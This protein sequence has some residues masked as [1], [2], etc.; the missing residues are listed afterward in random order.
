ML[1]FRPLIRCN[2]APAS[3]IS[4]F[5]EPGF[6]ENERPKIPG[7]SWSIDMLKRKST[8]DLQTIWYTIIKEKNK[9]NTMQR[10][11]T[12]HQE[13]LGA[14]PAPSRALL[15]DKSLENIRK[16]LR[17]RHDRATERA[18]EIFEQRKKKGVYRYPPGPHEPPQQ[19]TST[20]IVT[21]SEKPLTDSIQSFFANEE[22]FESH[23]GIVDVQVRLPK[24]V[25]AK[26]EKAH[27]VFEEWFNAKR[28]YEDYRKYNDHESVWDT[29]QVEIAPG[30]YSS[31]P[32]ARE[33]PVPEPMKERDP[34]SD[35]MERLEWEGR[36]K[37]EQSLI[38]LGH[39]PNIT[40]KAPEHPGE[41]PEHPDEIAG[42]WEAE[43]TF[44]LPQRATKILE[45]FAPIKSIDGVE[46][47]SVTEV[48]F[49]YEHTY[50]SLPFY[51][52][53][54]Q[55][56]KAYQQWKKSSPLLSEWKDEYKKPLARPLIEIITHNYNNKI[57]YA[58]R[59]ARMMGIN[60]WEPP[61]PIDYTCG[62]GY[63][64]PLWISERDQ[65]DADVPR[66]AMEFGQ[67]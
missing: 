6:L 27:E 43:V 66:F 17:E 51:E 45:T 26:K 32:K 28:A 37:I 33:V 50:T 31:G 60:L 14:M 44:D 9:V 47:L 22:V 34:P 11:Y 58:E 10:H 13:T 61:V 23:K 59:E 67:Y 35:V 20:L 18:V 19:H 3:K 41:R 15:L 55:K 38:Q 56:E 29:V 21:F 36:T 63:Q 65:W 30:V 8:D 57:D 53:A 49:K 54:D 16:V 42:P 48:P 1:S 25:L 52:V 2:A 40:S 39:F 62:K 64:I 24:D 4:D 5:V 7:G 46:V 12:K